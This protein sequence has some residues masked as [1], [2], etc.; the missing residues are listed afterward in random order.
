LTDQQLLQDYTGRQ[1]ETAFAELVRRHVDFVFSAALRMVRDAHLAED[2][3]QGVFVALAQN[4]PQLADRPVLS[5]WLHLT[6]RNLAAKTVRSEVRRRAREQEAAAMHELLSAEPDATWEDIAPHLDAA[7]AE[8]DETDRDALMLRYFER[9]SA[10]EMAQTLGVSDEAAQKR[11]NRA[12]DRLRKCFAERG[13]AVG[14][15]GLAVVISANAVQAA[16]AGLAVSICTA[17]AL[18]GT[19][20]T[21]AA[22]ATITKTIA[23]T[24]LQKT[25]I[26]ATL[27]IAVGTG[28]YE[29]RQ[30]SKLR[31]QVNGFQQQQAPL[32]EQIQQ[33]QRERDEAT[34]R[35]AS[36]AD[37]LGTKGQDNSELL[38]LR[39]MAGVARRAIAEAEQLR[40]QLARQ[41]SET[42]NNPVNAAMADV[43][44]QAL[45]R[46]FEGR[47]SRMA[48]SLHLT[49][50]QTQAARDIL[51]RQ[52]RTMAAG[53]QQARSGKY[54]K[55]E[56]A[57]LAS[58]QGDTDAQIKALLTPDQQ[59][60]YASY[61]Q[62]E[63]A[64]NASRAANTELREMQT[65][66]DLS[67]EQLDRVYAALYEVSFHQ[68]TGSTKTS[69]GE[70]AGAAEAMQQ[71]MDQKARALEPILT[72]TQLAK[73][74]QQQASQLKLLKAMV[75]R[76][77]GSGSS[78]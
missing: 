35:L 69:P 43:M 27:T 9:K 34:N 54:D 25:I 38:R 55:E 14:A 46:Q 74:R 66:L 51:T 75:S 58:E 53:M 44:K 71:T 4:A 59:A 22:T 15:T 68:V 8:L 13:V 42:D 1:S 57:R 11:V 64:Y 31:D 73:Y 50:E 5:G 52:A 47:L 40:A 32:N 20:F 3:T 7:V 48:A 70:F 10:R 67:S 24:I 72:P 45:E 65:T 60:G 26:G 49:P 77:E 61:Q 62:E 41:A 6:A 21:T 56:L 30:N 76:M 33:L 36:L 18:V 78:N 16:P 28:I 2:V 39:G 29:A 19:T 23:M 63:A 37:T 12:V 17:A